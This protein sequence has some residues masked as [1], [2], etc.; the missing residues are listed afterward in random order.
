MFNTKFFNKKYSAQTLVFIFEISANENINLKCNYQYKT[1]GNHSN[2]YSCNVDDES[3]KIQ[4]EEHTIKILNVEN[5]W[6]V[7][8]FLIE[9]KEVLYFPNGIGKTFY[10][11]THLAIRHSKLRKFLPQN[12]ENLTQLEYLDLSHNE[13]QRLEEKTITNVRTI[14]LNNNRINFIHPNFFSKDSCNHLNL[15]NNNCISESAEGND[16]VNNLVEKTKKNCVTDAG[17]ESDKI[18]NNI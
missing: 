16:N 18:I 9:N 1:F 4:N 2:I 12:L 13:I 6:N 7:K 5:P 10:D 8:G 17:K 15:L 11:L 3:F 14:I